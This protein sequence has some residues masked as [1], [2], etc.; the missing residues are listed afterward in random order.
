MSVVGIDVGNHASCVARA[1]R[2]VPGSARSPSY[3]RCVAPHPPPLPSSKPHR[4]GVD[5]LL[6]QESSR[7]TPSCVFFGAKSRLAGVQ[8]AAKWGMAPANTVSSLKR[9]LG[10]RFDDPGLQAELP[11][12]P[13]SVTAGPDGRC[14]VNVQFM[15]EPASFTTEQLMAMVL[16]DQKKLAEAESGVSTVDCVLSVPA[17]YTE[18]QRLAML[19]AST[20]AGL[21]CLRLINE[22][23][24]TALAYGIYKTDLPETEP[25]HVAFVDVGHS[26]TQVKGGEVWGVLCAAATQCSSASVCVPLCARVR[27]FAFWCVRARVSS[28]RL[29]QCPH[30]PAHA[31]AP[32]NA[33]NACGRGCSSCSCCRGGGGPTRFLPCSK[34]MHASRAHGARRHNQEDS[35]SF[36]RPA[37]LRPH[38]CT[39]GG[40]AHVQHGL[41]QCAEQCWHGAGTRR[42]ARTYP[43]EQVRASALALQHCCP[44]RAAPVYSAA[45]RQERPHSSPAAADAPPHGRNALVHP[46]VQPCGAMRGCTGTHRWSCAP[47][48]HAGVHRGIQEVRHGGQAARV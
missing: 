46:L 28:S 38:A 15:G 6:N 32:A 18:S 39:Q 12:L 14:L 25:V 17:C 2:C 43:C 21:N 7:E 40:L 11:Y 20:I 30:A 42:Q 16:V 41:Q 31:S 35:G 29:R 1:A 13:F 34:R 47:L 5:V 27:V 36:P 48:M 4:R 3:A 44:P 37:P 22:D 23:T 19:N 24:A 8:A 33:A 45:Y 26:T 10:R 9:L